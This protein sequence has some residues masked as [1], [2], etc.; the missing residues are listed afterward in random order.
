MGTLFVPTR[1]E[2]TIIDELLQ[3]LALRGV[4][5]LDDVGC[6]REMV[7]IED[8]TGWAQKYVPTLLPRAHQ[9]T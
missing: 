4:W 1:D 3:M 6:G 5:N 7:L 9:G 2:R 8:G